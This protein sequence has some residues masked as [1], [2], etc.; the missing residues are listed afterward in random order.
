MNTFKRLSYQWIFVL[1]LIVSTLLLATASA[2]QPPPL[3]TP[4]VPPQNP[5]T[6]AKVNL[7]KI[8]F[9]EE[10]LSNTGTVACG[11]CHRPN[12]AGSDPRTLAHFNVGSTASTHPGPDALL[13]TADDIHASMGVP[14]HTAD[15]GYSLSMVFQTRPQV[16]ARKTPSSL[17]AGFSPQAMFW[18]G[19]ADTS[20]ADP[21]TG[22]VLIPQ[23]A[24]LENQALMPLLDTAEMAPAAAVVGSI[25]GRIFDVKP[26]AL[27]SQ[28]PP[29]LALWIAGRKYPALFSEVFGTP[30]VSPVRIAFAMA[31]YQRSLN[32]NQTPFDAFLGG[33]TAAL[34]PQE[35]R[36]LNVFRGTDCAGCHAGALT[37]DNSFRYIGVRPA[38][39]DLGRFNVTANANDRGRFKVASLR[40]VELRAPFM[41]T[42]KFNTLEEVVEFY[43]RGGDFNEP[44]KDPRVRPRNLTQGAKA[45]LLAFLKRPLTDP[46]V[47]AEQAPFDR[48]SLFSSSERVPLIIGN[49]V[50]GSS[51]SPNI[52]AIEPPILGSTNFT[53]AL[54]QA[55]ANAEVA[56]IVSATDPGET[57]TAT[58]LPLADFARVNAVTD[59]RGFA[60]LQLRLPNMQRWAGR[61][62]IGR[63]YV[64]DSSVANGFAVTK[65]FQITLFGESD[66]LSADGFE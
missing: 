7:G 59:A 27:A 58:G 52:S 24:A 10:Q 40:N 26:L 55:R 66:V 13:G 48:P 46:R 2:Q 61:N 34:T 15:G 54:T 43:N 9:W 37:S 29:A 32:S 39:E 17:N 22:I 21:L 62:L 63:I 57:V 44:N 6:D 45:D 23:G 65:A 35:Q 30:D 1:M 38:I 14:A 20:F 33:N 16:G 42:G 25:A 53:V 60:S 51:G 56:L 5:Q 11:T 28:I 47:S 19:R 8:L 41:H 64:S 36:G 3:G 18:D 4:P 12:S 50:A 31:S 49:S